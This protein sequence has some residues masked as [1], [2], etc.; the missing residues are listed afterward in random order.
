MMIVNKYLMKTHQM[1]KL[2]QQEGRPYC[3]G[4]YSTIFIL[5]KFTF[6]YL[7]VIEYCNHLHHLPTLSS[8]SPD[9]LLMHG[10]EC[11]HDVD[12]DGE[13]DGAVVLGGDAVQGLEVPQLGIE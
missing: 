10:H 11:G 8:S 7:T 2:D 12:G 9:L 3:S 4:Y 5:V 1:L 6:L 13:D